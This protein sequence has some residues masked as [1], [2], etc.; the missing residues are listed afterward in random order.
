MTVRFAGSATRIPRLEPIRDGTPATVIDKVRVF[1]PRRVVEAVLSPELRAECQ[2][3]REA[4]LAE[5]LDSTDIENPYDA[6][7][8]FILHNYNKHYSYGSF[9]AMQTMVEH[10]QICLD[11]E[12][13]D[14]YLAMPP[15]WRASGRMARRAMRLLG[16][17][18]MD[19]PDAENWLPAR[20][21][22]ALQVGAQLARGALRRA[23]LFRATPP[24][25][26]TMTR[27]AWA[28]YDELLRRD[29][30]LKTRL[31]R[32][33]GEAALMDTG[34]FDQ[35]GVDSIVAEHLEGRASH[36]RLLVMLLSLSSWLGAHGYQ[37]VDGS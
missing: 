37:G 22:F 12:V 2:A 6:W 36:K 17:S 28:N 4:G 30:V 5:A 31:G 1:P 16:G 27:G 25:E 10:R 11:P 33:S 13:F 18:L 32:L 15:A 29:P 26:P 21:P 35:K 19:L 34:L 8:A 20:H 23:G 14:I 24:P 9:I 3:R 7:D